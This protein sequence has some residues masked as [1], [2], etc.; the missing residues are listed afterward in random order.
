MEDTK[1]LTLMAGSGG[2]GSV[3]FL[4]EKYRPNAGPDG[5]DGGEGGS[6]ILR[7]MRNLRSLNHFEGV[8]KVIAEDGL[9][10]K[11][12]K[13]T[14]RKGKPI[15]LDVPLGTIVWS[16][17]EE[18]EKIRLA[19]VLEE[20]ERVLIAYGGKGGI[21]NTHFASSVNQE[22]L[23]AIGGEPGEAREVQL[24]IKLLADVGL[25]GLPNAGKSS[26]LNALT[27]AN[28]KIGDYPFTTLEPILGVI[29]LKTGTLVM[30]DIPGLIENAHLGKGLGL[31]FLRHCERSAI[32]FQLIDGFSEDFGEDYRTINQELHLHNAGLNDKPRFV[33]VTKGDIPEVRER[34]EK[35]KE[36]LCKKIGFEPF[37]ISSASGE[38]LEVLYHALEGYVVTNANEPKGMEIKYVKPLPRLSSRPRVTFEENSFVVSCPPAE[39]ILATVNLGN[40]RARLQFHSQ[41]KKMGV[42][43]ALIR[44]KIKEGDTVFLGGYEFTWE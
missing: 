25:V 13:R 28:S 40:W 20:G 7:G 17:G 2:N 44:A 34:F 12:K 4:R 43:D 8:Y 6:V 26:L 39:R 29:T 32:L 38:G 10:G 42:M 5:G 19:E 30:L 1:T 33:F 36:E 3:S 22:P 14:G 24:E 31:E 16:I 27:R 41:L 37:L 21:G 15:Y 9:P 11:S 35:Q 23:L 18:E